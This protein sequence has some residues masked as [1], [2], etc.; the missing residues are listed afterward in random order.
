MMHN[1]KRYFVPVPKYYRQWDGVEKIFDVVKNEMD[2]GR[3][4]AHSQYNIDGRLF[5]KFIALI[6][7][8][9]G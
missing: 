9:E 7:Y 6:I 5:I 8:M 1:L 2:G 4:R 3:L